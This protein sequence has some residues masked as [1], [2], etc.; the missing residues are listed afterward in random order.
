MNRAEAI[1]QRE[2][3]RNKAAEWFRRKFRFAMSESNF[4][5]LVGCSRYK[6]HQ[7]QRECQRRLRQFSSLDLARMGH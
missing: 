7:G 3:L 5:R 2:K 6:P 4:K 1:K